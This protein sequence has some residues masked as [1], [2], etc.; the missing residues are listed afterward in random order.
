[1]TTPESN[2]SMSNRR[3]FPRIYVFNL[4]IT[5]ESNEGQNFDVVN[6]ALGGLCLKSRNVPKVAPGLPISGLIVWPEKNLDRKIS[7]IVCWSRISEDGDVFYGVHT[8]VDWMV[9]LIDHRVIDT[10]T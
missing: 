3:D 8:N 5:F 6:A 4:G 2:N 9:P 7:G 1:M 10:E